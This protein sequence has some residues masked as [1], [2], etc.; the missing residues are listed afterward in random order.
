MNKRFEFSV[1]PSNRQANRQVTR[2]AARNPRRL[3]L[4]IALAAALSV[5]PVASAG[6]ISVTGYTWTGPTS[7]WAD[8][9]NWRHCTFVLAGGCA[10]TA[11]GV[12]TGGD[13]LH[14]VANANVITF[15]NNVPAGTIYDGNIIFETGAGAFDFSGGTIG[16]KG[17]ITNLGSKQQVFN[18][19]IDPYGDQTWNGG[20]GG[21]KINTF[22]A[23]DYSLDLSN[24]VSLVSTGGSLITTVGRS[25]TGTLNIATSSAVAA[26]T[27][28]IGEEFGS[29]G[30]VNLKAAD[31]KLSVVGDL[32]IGI[33]GEGTLN[34]LSGA[35]ASSQQA[36][37]GRDF[38][39]Q[40]TVL[41]DGLVSKLAI[42]GDLEVGRSSTGTVTVQNGGTLTSGNAVIGKALGGDGLV[43]LS[44]AGANWISTG[45]LSIGEAG[46][47]S[48]R[49]EAGA[50]LSNVGATL[51]NLDGSAGTAKVTGA[52][53]SW[54]LSGDLRIGKL[55]EGS[56]FIEQGGLVSNQH[57]FVGLAG[58]A[59][60][61]RVLV[62]GANA[63]WQSSGNLT[64]Q[65]GSLEIADGGAVSA[66][67]ARFGTTGAASA[68]VNLGGTG[69]TLTVTS[70]LVIGGD[71]GTATVNLGTG[72][73]I[74]SGNQLIVGKGGV[75]NLNGGTLNTGWSTNAGQVNWNSGTV[76]FL[77][78]ATSGDGILDHS[79][80]LGQGM[81]MTVNGALTILATDNL[82]LNG[83]Q[84]Q[85]L[86]LK[87][88]GELAVGSFSQLSVGAGGVNNS[89][90]VQLAGGKISSAGA[91]VSA[92]YL[93]GYGVIAGAG[94][95]SNTGL[96]QQSGGS[97]E[98]ATTGANRNTGNWDLL[99]GRGLVLSGSNL[100]N[101][102]V[103]TLNGDTISGS[104]GLRNLAAG[105][106]SGR[107]AITAGFSNA[108]RL[109]V[110]SGSLRVDRES[111]ENSGLI[112]MGSA[113]ATLSGGVIY[114]Q[115]RI[116]GSGQIN[117]G[118][119][120]TG[121]VM[122]LGSGATLV[123]ASGFGNN[124]GG[125][126]VA[127]SGAT[128]LL[129]SFGRNLGQMQL[130]GGTIDT[131]GRDFN[132]EAGGVISGFGTLRSGTVSND[133]QIQ[134]S[135]GAS[136]LHADIVSASG[137]KIIL[138]G[139]SNNT[140]Y[141]N[142]DIQKG[143]ELRFSTG[144]FTT[145]FGN[146]AQRTGSLFKGSGTKLYEGALSV[147][148][149]PGLGTDEGSLEFGDSSTYLAEIGGVTA[150]T[151]ACDNDDALKN[152]SFDKYIVSGSLSLA[153][154]LKLVSWNGFVAQ[155]GQ[156]FDL[157]DWGSLSGQFNTID[158]SGLKLAAGTQLDYSQL[159]TS[160]EVLVTT[161]AVP[162]PG[163]LAL[164]LS[165]LVGL[166][167]LARRRRLGAGQLG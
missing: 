161:S 126:L 60:F 87:V 104:A 30:T 73:T 52:N 45:N 102:G 39:S 67:E 83:G 11:T 12:P 44:G 40:G 122:A 3:P 93:G 119:D 16:L 150:C 159:Y 158:A 86:S 143:A 92:S 91:I 62:T 99:S 61:S 51:A 79:V 29:I 81:N 96:L 53:A 58:D 145:F 7:N 133:G 55:G 160:G 13:S 63:R 57:S 70:N 90:A 88:L 148:A 56:L 137:S 120:N 109:V 163:A 132:N 103:M 111:F 101:A 114:N 46:V 64:L 54:L 155:A 130:A 22:A 149:S 23:L 165:G 154:T 142:V 166:G 89:G 108:G 82:S 147:G 146:V 38:G 17:G 9:N 124:T 26:Q 18:L 153:G 100:D 123:L 32:H 21:L 36:F 50:K 19:R 95:F 125:T 116:Q 75:L 4:S 113:T 121:T 106:I 48:L 65:S 74:N 151:L 80:G 167:G 2:R 6:A 112:L 135:G 162:E 15:I 156:H 31:A 141:G 33:A 98:L 110:D 14:F 76:N 97:L 27:L 42:S 84:A 34:V 138:S 10:V 164:W 20:T 25:A 78:A 127:N 47:G 136:T 118:I 129:R 140:F 41:V 72:A 24:K 1:S 85:A 68:L 43:V 157:L 105:T 139:Q 117:N 152:S 77:G 37:I 107:G 144:S 66:Q 8:A 5:G 69:S 131:D 28:F 35:Q 134:L 115:G 59:G 128:L 94:G 71:A 49:V